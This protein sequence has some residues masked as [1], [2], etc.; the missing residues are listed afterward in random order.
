MII[1]ITFSKTKKEGGPKPVFLFPPA[2]QVKGV[3]DERETL[4][5]DAADRN[6]Y[7]KILKGRDVC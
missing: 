7:V 1:Q 2:P 6:G 3:S 4:V 5:L